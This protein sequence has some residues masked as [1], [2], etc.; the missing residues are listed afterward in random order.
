MHP[1]IEN[2][3]HLISEICKKYHVNKL[4]AFGSVVNGN[5][6]EKSDIDLLYEFDLESFSWRDT[7]YDYIDN[8]NAF[9]R[10][11]SDLFERKVDL[12]RNSNFN[13]HVFKNKV[14]VSKKLLY[15]K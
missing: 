3:K 15:A 11:L 13:N 6:T 14:A 7:E 2:K 10:K 8:L 12:I 5:F 1:L 4:F 9:E